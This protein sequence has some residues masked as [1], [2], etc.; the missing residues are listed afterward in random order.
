MFDIQKEDKVIEALK[1][2]KEMVLMLEEQ[3]RPFWNHGVDSIGPTALYSNAKERFD[4]VV[5]EL[6]GESE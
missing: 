6:E 5:A 2:L 1:L 4:E 3:A